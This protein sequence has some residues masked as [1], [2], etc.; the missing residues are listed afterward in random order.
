[1]LSIR[2][3]HRSFIAMCALASGLLGFAAYQEDTFKWKVH[4]M[5]RPKPVVVTPGTF[6]TAEKPGT[7]PSD[8]KVLLGPGTG[9]DAWTTNGGDASWDVTED[10]I[11][12]VKG[13]DIKT[14]ENFRNV[15]I[16]VEWMIPE[17]RECN[18]QAGCNSGVFFMDQYEVQILGTHNNE[19][20]SDGMAGSLY[21]QNPPLVNV[22][23]PNGQWN[24]YD[25][26]FQAPVF[27]DN[28]DLVSPAY[29]T[30]I[31]NGV[32]VQNNFAMTGTTAHMARA[33]YKKHADKMP[34]RIQDHS[35]PIKFANIWVMEIPSHQTAE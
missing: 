11:A 35:D 6:G 19:S 31:F 27:A 20:Y 21:G 10:G 12:Q 29:V 34:I 7:P 1:M 33:K 30:V 13:G 32:V 22:C 18:G 28:G 23:R 8:V 24:S 9:L 26:L 14:R 16:H 4:D 2:K 17:D 3:S 5:D 25:I 15:Q